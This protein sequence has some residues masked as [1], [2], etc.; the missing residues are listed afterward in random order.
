MTDPTSQHSQL[1]LA[2]AAIGEPTDPRTQS[3]VAKHL[4]DALGAHGEVLVTADT[5]LRPMQRLAAA[6]ITAHRNRQTWRSRMRRSPLTARFR[7]QNLIGALR[8]S[9][10]PRHAVLLI[11]GIYE[12]LGEPYVP[13]LDNSAVTTL[14][15]WPEWGPWHGRF[16]E[17]VLRAECSYL[18]GATHVFTA[19]SLVARDIVDGHGLDPADVT[20]I[21]AG[22]HFDATEGPASV[23]PLVLFVGYDFH[24]KGGDVL[25]QAFPLVR[26]RVP[27]ARLIVVGPEL[28]VDEPGVEALGPVSDRDELRRLYDRAAAFV[29]PARYEPYGMVL[30]EAMSRG[31]PCIGT[32]V[33]AIPEII[34]NGRTGVVVPKND[35]E[36]LAAAIVMVLQNPELAKRF[37]AAGRERVLATHNWDS[38]ARHML[39]VL[40]QKL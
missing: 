17:R 22:A 19:G 13:Y 33:C 3:G 25:L 29:L 26:E 18:Q 14:R 37:G 20:V 23:E 21:G 10:V 40:S 24:R 4:V 5:S 2:V 16:R 11:R 6:A 38:V 15:D 28:A 35:S 8:A 30:L 39:S 36:A 34:E 32:D 12:P 9:D 31:I 1:R 27:E 7:T